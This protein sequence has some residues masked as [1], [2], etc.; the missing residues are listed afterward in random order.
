MVQISSLENFIK[1]SIWQL[2][3][4][5][6]IVKYVPKKLKNGVVVGDCAVLKNK[7]NLYD[8]Y[9]KQRKPLKK[10]ISN[11]KVAII[12]ATIMSQYT[13]KFKTVLNDLSDLDNEY[14]ISLENWNRYKAKID[15]SPHLEDELDAWEE[16]IYVLSNQIEKIY[17]EYTL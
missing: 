11:H 14:Q 13:T 8:V 12:I 5:G 4:Q 6:D 7:K 9:S 15:T 3:R 1:K 16:Q 2:T 10:D 17:C